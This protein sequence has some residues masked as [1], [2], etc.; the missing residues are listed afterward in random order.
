M[1]MG[2]AVDHDGDGGPQCWR[3]AMVVATGQECW[4]WA[5]VL[6][7]GHGVGD[8]SL[9]WHVGDGP[10]HWRGVNT[11]VLAMGHEVADRL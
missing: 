6:V 1:A 11:V 8:G 7:I 4:R 3:W 2:L 9:C 10:R 5:R